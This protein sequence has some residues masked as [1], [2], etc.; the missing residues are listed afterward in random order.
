MLKKILIV[1]ALY[2]A[3]LT[4]AHKYIFTG[5]PCCG[6]TTVINEMR[7]R[8]YQVCP[9]AFGQLYKEAKSQG[10]LHEF[11]KP[12]V[13]QRYI[14]V[15]RHLQLEE[16]LDIS[17]PSF[18]DRGI[19]DAIF[20]GY[21][22]KI[23]MP[24]DLMQLFQDHRHDYAKVFFFEPVPTY[25]STP[26]PIEHKERHESQQEA[27]AIH[28]ALLEGYEKH[29]FKVVHVP[30]DSVEKRIDFILKHIQD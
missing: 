13:A 19:P 29:G 30:F 25:Y 1:I 8:G 18:L 5:G 24:E 22:L 26:L 7:E 27:L 15:N 20:Y 12:T 4:H 16:A 14:V 23:N 3:S 11:L 9:E 2:G 17:K 10:V 6:K 21:Y 28:K